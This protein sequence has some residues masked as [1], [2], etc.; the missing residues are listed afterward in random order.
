M[1]NCAKAIVLGGT[2]PHI[3]LI[4]KLQKRGFYVILVDY[5]EK[6]PA[7]L[8]A[9]EHI[10]ESTLDKEAVLKI[11][12]EREVDLVI[13]T[14]ID[15]ANVTACYIGEKLGLPIPYSYKTALNVTDKSLMKEMM[16]CNKIPTSKYFKVSKNDDIKS[17]EL[18]Y[19]VIVKPTDSNSSKGVRRANDLTE[20]K[21]FLKEALEISRNDQAIV[22]EYVEGREIG[23]DSIC[24][25]GKVNLVISRERTKIISDSDDT[26]QIYGSFWPASISEEIKEDFIKIS[27]K[28]AKVFE[29]DNTPLMIQAIVNEDGINIIEFAPRIGGGENFNII[30]LSTG[31]EII[32][33]AIDSFLG[34]EIQLNINKPS[35]IYFDNY[36]YTKQGVFN[37][38]EGLGKLIENHI[39]DYYNVYKSYGIPIG[40]DLTSNNRVG[41]FTVKGATRAETIKKIQKAVQE[42]EVYDVNDQPIMIKNIYQN[43]KT[44]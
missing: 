17:I 6:P 16:M 12:K 31:F 32:E 5:H 36:I 39:A 19:P 4:K 27:E 35:N 29:F 8:I 24:K 28:I 38:I 23:I 15:Q 22:E 3:T 40:K 18:K 44:N 11:A 33:S 43:L 13:S 10:Q 2:F 25:N 26:Q 20:L 41:V 7:K 1:K 9:D 34:K 37:N 42:I 14:C 21:L 30:K